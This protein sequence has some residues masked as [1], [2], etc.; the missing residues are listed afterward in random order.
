M[1]TQC[2][3]VGRAGNRCTSADVG[4]GRELGTDPRQ[5]EGGR[6]TGGA[7]GCA[8]PRLLFSQTQGEQVSRLLSDA[9]GGQMWDV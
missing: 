3:D 4:L 1:P 2:E 8:R 7:R 5:Q 6:R 9:G